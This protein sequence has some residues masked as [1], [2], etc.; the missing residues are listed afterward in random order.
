MGALAV[1]PLAGVRVLDFSHALAGP[2]CTMLLG[3][4]GADVIK[5]EPPG[6][7]HSRQWGPPFIKGESSYFLSVNRNKRSVVLDLKKPV[8]RGVAEDLAM[9]CDVVVENFKPGTMA[10]LGLDAATLQAKKPALVYASISGFGQNQPSLAG[11]DQIAQG[12]SGMMSVNAT[13]DSRPTKVGVPIG[14][15]AAGMFACQAILAAL[16]ERATTGRGRYIDVA[17]NDSLLALFT[18][19]A[20]RYFASGKVPIQEGNHHATIAPYGTFAVSDGFINVAVA[21][22]AQFLRFCEAIRAPELATDPRFTSNALRQGARAQLV[23]AIDAH[24]REGTRSE[25]LARFEQFGIPAGPILDIEEAF[26]SPLATQR[27]MRQKIEHPKAGEINQVGAPWKIDGQ[28]SP[29]RKPP[30]LLGQ[31]TAEVVRELLH[32]DA[33]DLDA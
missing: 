30:P 2:Y 9:A 20:G 5:V 22:D 28:S 1:L 17:L 27:E 29:I 13:P 14:D 3:D 31:H 25:W 19:Q 11:Y 6:G 15:I 33:G 7:D 8:S 21:S 26:A 23:A 12:T 16:V 4:L 10:R 32:R 18:Y 24:L